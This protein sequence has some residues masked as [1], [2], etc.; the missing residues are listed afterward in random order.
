MGRQRV[1]DTRT[2][3]AWVGE[4]RVSPAAGD[5][6]NRADAELV[7]AQFAPESWE[8]FV[9]AH[10]AALR[11]AA[12]V[13]AVHGRPTGRHAPRTVW[14]MLTTVE[15]EL[16]AWAA[17]FAAGAKTRTAIEAGRFDAVTEESAEQLLCAAEDF[18]DDVRRRVAG[19]VGTGTSALA[20]RAS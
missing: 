2:L 6:M 10:L 5:L 3:G 14:E 20:L 18:V 4:P 11:A 13:V 9:H 15:P 12:A 1:V 8:R 17:L 19:P 7:A 16:G